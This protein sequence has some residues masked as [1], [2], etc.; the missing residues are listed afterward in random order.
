MGRTVPSFRNVPEEE[1]QEWKPLRNTL[2]KSGGKS[3]DEM[4][5]FL[6]Y[7]LQRAPILFRMYYSI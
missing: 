5:T 4:L 2:D 7:T 3:F 6:D 1:K